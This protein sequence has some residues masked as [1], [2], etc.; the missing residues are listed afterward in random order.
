MMKKKGARTE[1]KGVKRQR[2]MMKKNG[3]ESQSLRATTQMRVRI[4]LNLIMATK[5]TTIQL[6]S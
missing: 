5:T 6:K 3:G 2:E 4:G 1:N